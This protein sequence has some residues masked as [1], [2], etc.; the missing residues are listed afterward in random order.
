MNKNL[1]NFFSMKLT[2]ELLSHIN[3]WPLNNNLLHSETQLLWLLPYSPWATTVDSSTCVKLPELYTGC[4]SWC[5]P[6]G[7]CLLLGVKLGIFCFLWECVNHYTLVLHSR[8]LLSKQWLFSLNFWTPSTKTV[9]NSN[10][11]SLSVW[12]CAAEQRNQLTSHHYHFRDPE[13]TFP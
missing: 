7:L 2:Q 6:K 3:T 11:L 5:N 4:P 13:Y 8:I 1:N 12:H 9:S 10:F